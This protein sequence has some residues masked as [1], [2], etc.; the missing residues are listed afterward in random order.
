MQISVQN[1]PCPI[2]GKIGYALYDGALPVSPGEI[3]YPRTTRADGI[4]FS[5]EYQREP[6]C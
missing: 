2:T 5:L 1:G 6:Q 4:D 3:I